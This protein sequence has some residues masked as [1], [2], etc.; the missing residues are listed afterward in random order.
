VVGGK[1]SSGNKR[2]ANAAIVTYLVGG[3]VS[4]EELIRT[5]HHSV[6]CAAH[7]T[8]VFLNHVQMDSETV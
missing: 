7:S 1:V 4:F 8:N 2:R 5:V 3:P 6:S